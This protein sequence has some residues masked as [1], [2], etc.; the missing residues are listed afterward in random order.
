MVDAYWEFI[1]LKGIQKGIIEYDSLE[2]KKEQQK[3]KKISYIWKK[4]IYKEIYI[5]IYYMNT[6]KTLFN[7]FQ[8]TEVL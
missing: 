1:F 3:N 4:N 8:K 5:Y 7:S 2:S 6:K